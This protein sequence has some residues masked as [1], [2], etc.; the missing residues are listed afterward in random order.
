VLVVAVVVDMV[1][2]EEQAEQAVELLV[3]IILGQMELLIL[4][5]ALLVEALLAL[6]LLVVLADQ[7]L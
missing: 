1:L 7:A 5:V 6:M 2:L 4:V 3:Q